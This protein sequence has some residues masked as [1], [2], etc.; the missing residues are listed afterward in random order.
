MG[1]VASDDARVELAG[2]LSR[3]G[4]S[5][6]GTRPSR[7]R[8]VPVVATLIVALGVAGTL[9]WNFGREPGTVEPPVTIEIPRST[10][11]STTTSV[12]TVTT[13]TSA[14]IG[15]LSISEPIRELP[16]DGRYITVYRSAAV[17]GS[18]T[19][20]SDFDSYLTF[21]SLEAGL[22]PSYSLTRASCSALAPDFEGRDLYIAYL[23]P[24]EDVV[25]ACDNREVLR[26]FGISDAYVRH[27]DESVQPG[28]DEECPA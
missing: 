1:T 13:V 11:A 10:A 14:A 7:P 28:D 12:P 3:P 16:C 15:D 23:G 19:F 25:E 17:D 4:A 21:A 8:L 6:R 2:P 5:S 9:W 26:L 20:A 27:L 24:V 22:D 18:P